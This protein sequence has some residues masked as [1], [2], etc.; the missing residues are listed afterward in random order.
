MPSKKVSN[1]PKN[2]EKE[3]AK[4]GKAREDPARMPVGP[5]P[6]QIL[7]EAEGKNIRKVSGR[8]TAGWHRLHIDFFL[9]CF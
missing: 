8:R 7:A 2:K 6:A 5:T 1:K 3:K 4:K 9:S